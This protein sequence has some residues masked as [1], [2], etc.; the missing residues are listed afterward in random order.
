METVVITKNS[1][2][3]TWDLALFL[4]HLLDFEV[5]RL[6]KWTLWCH[7]QDLSSITKYSYF[8][9]SDLSILLICYVFE[10]TL[11]DLYKMVLLWLYYQIVLDVSKCAQI[12]TIILYYVKSK[13]QNTK[14]NQTKTNRMYLLS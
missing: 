4:H 8:I 2:D 7:W 13:S 10:E 12:K 1:A 3:W 11:T 5:V 14:T 6:K 9:L